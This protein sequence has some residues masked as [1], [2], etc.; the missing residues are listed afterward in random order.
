MKS[1]ILTFVMLYFSMSISAGVHIYVSPNGNDDNQGSKNTPL[2]SIEGARNMIRTLRHDDNFKSDT[3]FVE[4]LPGTYFISHAINLTD[5]DGGSKD[6]PVIFRGD[7]NNRP[8]ISGGR[9]IKGFKFVSPNLWR[10]FIP[11]AVS[12]VQFKQLYINGERRFLARTPNYG[13]LG[14]IKRFDQLSPSSTYEDNDKAVGKMVVSDKDWPILNQINKSDFNDASLILYNK[15]TSSR[16]Q[17]KLIDATDSTLY[18]AGNGFNEGLMPNNLTSFIIENYPKA[19][20]APG[21]WILNHDGYLYYIPKDGESPE[22]AVAT[23]PVAEKLLTVTGKEGKEAGYI[24]FENIKFEYSA[25]T[26]DENKD[27]GG[28]VASA[29]DAAIM[30][31]YANNIAFHNCDIA[32][33]G[34]H[35][36]WMRKNCSYSEIEHCHIYDLGCG[37]IKIGDYMPHYFKGN[38][39]VDSAHTHNIVVDNNIIQHGGYVFPCSGG[40]VIFHGSD[41]TVTHND[42]ADFGYTGI[43]V[44]WIWGYSPSP[45]KRNKIKFNHIHHLGWGE[46]SDMGGVYTLGASEG[47]TVNNNVIHHIYSLAY[48]GWGLYTDEGSTGITMKNNLVYRCK[49][50]G[51]HQHYGKDN[52]ITNNI[53]ALNVIN[54]LQISN[55]EKHRQF[56]FSHNIVYFDSDTLL[57]AKKVK[58]GWLKA[59]MDMD[60]N[61]YWNFKKH[62]FDFNKITFSEWQKLGHDN[63]SVIADP[64]FVNPLNY[65]FHFKSLRVAKKIGFKPFDYTQAGVY[66]SDEWKKTALLPQ[67]LLQRF[68]K[69]IEKA[70]KKK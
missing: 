30:V 63:H 5:A 62:D 34:Q 3:I 45:S 47:T 58:G 70:R 2:A 13:E 10:I 64:L 33:T 68:D 53:I 26:I 41:N 61:C 54:E 21:E 23:Y 35:G 60:R 11:E 27:D 37:G 22:T 56:T 24:S 20:D 1:T 52:V 57:Y 18:F 48:G 65:D 42:I 9:N 12:D 28:Q 43:S 19:L 39:D 36:L 15:W 25:F 50:A 4:I 32:H 44:G 66:G 29:T 16:R 59:N 69:I 6:A 51:F 7:K 40:V 55:V 46:L 31:N 67:Y 49:D 17:I 8:I 14:T 38:G